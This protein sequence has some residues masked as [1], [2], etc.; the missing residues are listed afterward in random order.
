MINRTGLNEVLKVFFDELNVNELS[1]VYNEK[2]NC[3]ISDEFILDDIEQF[4]KIDLFNTAGTVTV[5]YTDGIKFYKTRD[6]GQIEFK[7]NKW[8]II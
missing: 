7:N 2:L 8:E 5:G 6:L 3:F 1:V 4:I